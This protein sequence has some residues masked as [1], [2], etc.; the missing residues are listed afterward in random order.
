M[1][2]PSLIL[3]Q[4]YTFNSLSNVDGAVKFTLKN[5]LSDAQMTGL[6][7]VRI[8]DHQLSPAAI[9]IVMGDGKTVSP[10]DIS[11]QNPVNFPVKSPTIKIA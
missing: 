2:I 1:L 7:S 6:K 11:E 5:R 8:G 9:T 3:K 10:I 4:L